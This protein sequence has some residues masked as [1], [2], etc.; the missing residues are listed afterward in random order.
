MRSIFLKSFIICFTFCCFCFGQD[1]SKKQVTVK[2]L[3]EGINSDYNDYAPCI[4]PDGKIFYFSSD[5]KADS[6]GKSDVYYSEIVNGVFQPVKNAGDMF[7]TD[8]YEGAVSFT[9]DGKTVVFAANGRKDDIGNEDI[10]IGDVI[11]GKITN[12][13]NLGPKVNSKYW[14]SQPSISG[15]G[16]TIFF[17]SNRKDGIGK[18]DIWV[19]VKSPDG[20]FGEAKNLGEVINTD[21]NERSPFITSDGK[22]LYFSSDGLGGE[23]GKDIF[24]STFENGAWSK[25][26]NLGTPINSKRDDCFMF[27]LKDSKEFYFVSDRNDGPGKLDIY[28][29]IISTPAPVQLKLIVSVVDSITGKPL[30][31]NVEVFLEKER[32]YKFDI[33]PEKP[34][35][36]ESIELNK[37]YLVKATSDGYTPEEM[38]VPISKDIS[39]VKAVFQLAKPKPI[40]TEKAV[41]EFK[42][43]VSFLD[44]LSGLPLPAVI[45]VTDISTNAKSIINTNEND[46][47]YSIMLPS[48]RD[49]KVEGQ[50]LGQEIVLSEMVTST[51][52]NTERKVK[53]IFGPII[54]K[55]YNF[56]ETSYKVPFF[57]TGYYRPN[58]PENLDGIYPLTQTIL[59]KATYIEKFEKNSER[60]KA[61][62]DYANI[63]KEIFN[64]V[65]N[66]AVDTCFPYFKNNMTKNEVLEIVVIGHV[67]PRPMTAVYYE[68]DEVKFEDFQDNKYSIK[69]NGKIDNFSLSGLRAWHSGYYLDKLFKTAAAKNKPEYDILVKNN[70]IRYKYIAGFIN[71]EGFNLE[72]QR[73]IRILFTRAKQK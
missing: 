15:D 28:K 47:K 58:T 57:I 9:A 2:C 67:D 19:T 36:T 53:F 65:Y 25:P 13:K 66:Y 16:N 3:P 43:T 4:T 40:V 48:G 44:S 70:K 60:Y 14:D 56:S 46:F 32:I 54:L 61:Y 17:A 71:R 49:Y 38:T 68:N 45:T 18:E 6:K 37:K 51:K 39:Y 55:E 31:S 35:H 24:I 73:N 30:K 64:A 59:K 21:K 72:A 62:K 26:V 8:D 33:T 50:R 34:E 23:G 22:Y 29:G 7:N 52:K 20:T 10:Y 11:N 27:F 1:L 41:E 63:V 5:R 42:L 12:V 69:K